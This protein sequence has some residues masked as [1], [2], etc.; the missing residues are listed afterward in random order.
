LGLNLFY[1]AIDWAME[2]MRSSMEITAGTNQSTD[3]IAL[4][5]QISYNVLP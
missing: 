1:R 5:F 3:M 4:F 2:H